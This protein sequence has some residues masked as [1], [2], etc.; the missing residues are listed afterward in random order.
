MTA[1]AFDRG[2][3]PLRHLASN[4]E[5]IDLG[6]WTLADFEQGRH[7][8]ELKPLTDSLINLVDRLHAAFD[9]ERQSFANAAH[10]MKSSIAIVRSTL[11]FAFQSS[12]SFSEIIRPTTLRILSHPLL[13]ADPPAHVRFLTF[14]VM[15][16][17]SPKIFIDALNILMIDT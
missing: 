10:E 11:Q 1:W 7:L 3:R 17:F 13:L 2:L 9:R 4:A 16:P 8:S 15:T 6:R 12:I 14:V 5:T